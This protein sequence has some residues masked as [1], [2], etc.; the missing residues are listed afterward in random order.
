MRRRTRM[1]VEKLE[2]ELESRRQNVTSSTLKT[3]LGKGLTLLGYK[4]RGSVPLTIP[5]GSRKCIGLDGY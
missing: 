3:A 1:E 2:L 4:R 5:T